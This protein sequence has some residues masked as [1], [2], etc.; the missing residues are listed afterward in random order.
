MKGNVT[1]DRSFLP[2][3]LSLSKGERQNS[4]MPRLRL[5]DFV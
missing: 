5:I 1:A 4:L 3:A 2:F